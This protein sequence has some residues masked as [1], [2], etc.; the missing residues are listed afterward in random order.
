MI[1]DTSQRGLDIVGHLTSTF[2]T[3]LVMSLF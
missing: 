2:F 1:K 3:N